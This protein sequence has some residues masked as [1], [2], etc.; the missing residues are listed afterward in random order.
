MLDKMAK[1]QAACG[2]AR[3]AWGEALRA[4][5]KA[6]ATCNAASAA[7]EKALIGQRE[8]KATCRV[9]SATYDK[10]R[11]ELDKVLAANCANSK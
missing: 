10:A 7:L 3:V 5:E 6:K 4:Y 11:S 8:A 1:A 2:K 9:V